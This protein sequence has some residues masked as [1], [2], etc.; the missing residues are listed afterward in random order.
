MSKIPFLPDCEDM[1]EVD[2]LWIPS[3]KKFSIREYTLKQVNNTHS[4]IE[5]IVDA[6]RGK[7]YKQRMEEKRQRYGKFFRGETDKP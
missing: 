2:G 4:N 1:I 5:D 6:V 7:T 3:G